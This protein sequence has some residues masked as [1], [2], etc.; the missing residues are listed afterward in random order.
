MRVWPDQDSLTASCTSAATTITVADTTLY[1]VNE[2][3]EIE[4]ENLIV[5]AL[6]SGT[7]LTVER[8]TYGSSAASH[9]S[10]TDVLLRPRFL[11]L[12]IIDAINNGI[13]ACWPYL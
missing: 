11:Q 1:Y 2:P 12:E 3:L 8:A 4:S 6:T 5:R 7:V 9:A 10:G 13:D